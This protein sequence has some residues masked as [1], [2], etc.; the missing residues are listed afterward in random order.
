[1]ADRQ[2]VACAFRATDTRTYTYHND[3]PP[4]VPGD[5]V[6]VAD[7]SGD[8]WRRVYV[9]E[10]WCPKPAFETKPILGIAEPDEEPPVKSKPE[11]T[12]PVT[13]DLFG[14]G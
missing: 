10:V 12:P 14:E 3:G 8:G 4:V 9:R 1:M 6:K 7:K 5:E 13:R 2:F 11:P